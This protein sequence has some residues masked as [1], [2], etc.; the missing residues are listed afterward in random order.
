ME[1]VIGS[2]GSLGEYGARHEKVI[3]RKRISR[4]V[5]KK[6]IA[7]ELVLAAVFCYL[8]IYT[9][10][11]H[12]YARRSEALISD[13]GS[14][15]TAYVTDTASKSFKNTRES[16]K[17]VRDETVWMK[18][19]ANYRTGPDTTYER[20]GSMFKY[21]A[22]ARTGVTYNDWSRVT[23]NGEE[24]YIK[25]HNLTTDA[26]PVTATGQK[27]QYQLFALSKLASYGWSE[28][29]I[30]PLIKLWDRESGW[31]PKAHNGS[32][33]AHG[34][35][36]ALPASKMAAFGSDYYTNGNTQ[37]LWGLSYIANRYGSP[38]RAWGHFC[39]SGWY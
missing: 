14:F 27:G 38:S 6:I 39:S 36:Q 10:L 32:S 12:I 26:P 5:I 4:S 37:I 2:R 18:R 1:A 21:A 13:I 31:N 25:S 34:I 8:F 35:P 28:S 30:Y 19:E 29:E 9:S 3:Y 7:A 17:E 15:N 22:V 23:I 33:G 16:V 11:S 20:L 24:C